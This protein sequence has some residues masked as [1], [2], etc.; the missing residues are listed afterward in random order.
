MTITTRPLRHPH[1][2]R[3]NTHPSPGVQAPRTAYLSSPAL[4][5]RP[6]RLRP[7]ADLVAQDGRVRPRE[8]LFVDLTSPWAYLAHLRW[9]TDP[10][11]AWAAVQRPTT[12]P[13]T[14]LLV[15]GPERE[16]L[17]AELAQVRAAARPDE[18]LPADVPPVLPHPR[19]VAAAY[20][21]AEDLGVAQQVRD[22]L[23]RAYWLRGQD[24]GSPEVLRRL[25]PS[26][27]VTD[28]TLCT[29]DPRR[30]FGY[31]ISP[32]REPLSDAAYHLMRSWQQQWTALGSPGPLALVDSE[33]VARTDGLLD[34]PRQN[35][36]L[37]VA[38]EGEEDHQR[39]G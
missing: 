10:S 28:D 35:A 7:G 13:R 24:I 37:E 15:P 19:T 17:R 5:P 18:E 23:L 8:R 4:L 14:G 3:H 16:R 30:E 25:L 1:S 31:V 22:L 12:I 6:V 11:V 38:L 21:E 36:L 27:I 20:A 29:G 33:G 34:R 39:H 32:A 26:V 9:G 2:A